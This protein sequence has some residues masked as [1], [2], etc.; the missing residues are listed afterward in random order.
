[1]KSI[2]AS[3]FFAGAFFLLAPVAHAQQESRSRLS[4]SSIM[5]GA[6][7]PENAALNS[8]FS[9]FLEQG[10]MV[11]PYVGFQVELGGFSTSDNR[12]VV[13]KAEGIGISVKFVLPLGFIEPHL[14]A[15]ADLDW[16]QWGFPVHAA[17]GVDFNFGTLQVGVEGRQ[18]WYEA[19]GLNLDGLMVMEKIGIRF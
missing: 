3:A 11:N 10:F 8:E 19:D 15:G 9:F 12:K 13:T 7:L 6:Y 18:V 14:L 16:N 17:V 5:L 2:R 4:Y 1:M